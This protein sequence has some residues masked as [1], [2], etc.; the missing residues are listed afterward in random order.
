MNSFVL[1]ASLAL[2]WFT[3][4]A[5]PEA[6]SKRALFEERVAIIPELWR[7]EVINV[8]TTWQRRGEVSSAGA[9]EIL[10]DLLKLPFAIVDPGDPEMIIATAL[11]HDLSGYD[12]IYLRLAVLTSSPIATLDRKLIQAARA[13]GVG[14]A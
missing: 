2:E 9:S 1:D 6:L 13:V 11:A 5:R 3:K 7:C 8:L 4:G 14:I 12:A 10:K